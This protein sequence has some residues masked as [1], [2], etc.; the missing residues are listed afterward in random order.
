MRKWKFVSARGWYLVAKV[1]ECLVG[2]EGA[3]NLN[4]IHAI[5]LDVL[6]SH[7]RLV[8]KRI[9]RRV[10]LSLLSVEEWRAVK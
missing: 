2:G 7:R 4:R 6:T 8:G 9:A 1:L 5:F 3:M 10:K